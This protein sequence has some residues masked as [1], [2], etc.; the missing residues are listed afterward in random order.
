MPPQKKNDR[1][2]VHVED[3]TR[4]DGTP[5]ESH[6]RAGVN[7]KKIAASWTA[8]GVSLLVTIGVI[9]E[10][11]AVLLTTICII[12]TV[13]ISLFAYTVTTE[14]DRYQNRG[15]RGGRQR[16]RTNSSR[17]NRRRSGSSRSGGTRSGGSR[18]GTRQPARNRQPRGQ[19]PR[20]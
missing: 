3:Y 13:L 1:P 17:S 4:T 8:A 19:R 5:V 20:S 9:I 18:S 11:A 10:T 6:T 14:A 12:I 15:A 7:R 16:G 2:R